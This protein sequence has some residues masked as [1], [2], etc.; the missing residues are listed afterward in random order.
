MMSLQRTYRMHFNKIEDSIQAIHMI[1]LYERKGE[2]LI[3]VFRKPCGLLEHLVLYPSV[4]FVAVWGV[5]AFCSS[6]CN[7]VRALVRRDSE[8][9]VQRAGRGGDTTSHVPPVMSP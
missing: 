4:V 2:F 9:R 8:S 3:K 7:S 6:E 5:I 1:C